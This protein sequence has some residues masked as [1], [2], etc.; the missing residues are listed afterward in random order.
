MMNYRSKP[1]L[2]KWKNRKLSSIQRKDVAGLHLAI[3]EKSGHYAANRI[4]SLLRKMFNLGHIWG[5]FNAENPATGIEFF[6]EKKRE[7]FVLPEELPSLIKGLEKEPNL[8]IRGALFVCLMTGQRKGEVL[9]MKWED[10]DLEKGVWRIPRP[11]P[12]DPT[13]SPC[14]GQFWNSSKTF[15][16]FMKIPRFCGP[17]KFSFDQ[18]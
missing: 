3:G 10:V 13:F 16:T 6:Q 14:L 5:L 4:V 7:R 17:N 15:L 18:H 11:R 12:V 1:T 8:F 9:G 2:E